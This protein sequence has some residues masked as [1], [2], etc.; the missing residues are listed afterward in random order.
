[1]S[2]NHYLR[3]LRP[4][5][6]R[7]KITRDYDRIS[8]VKYENEW[9]SWLTCRMVRC[10]C[11]CVLSRKGLETAEN[12]QKKNKTVLSAIR[13]YRFINIVDYYYYCYC[14]SSNFFAI[15]LL[16]FR[17]HFPGR[18]GGLGQFLSSF[19]EQMNGGGGGG[20]TAEVD[21]TRLESIHHYLIY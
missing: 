10:A 15:I 17:V 5:R 12:R 7:E 13:R 1:M 6:I 9:R 8:I 14:Y 21:R 20:A 19:A 2:I 4:F 18:A 3:V 11:V 16:P